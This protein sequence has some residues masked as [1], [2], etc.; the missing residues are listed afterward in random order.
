[1]S[2]A[3]TLKSMKIF[4]IFNRANFYHESVAESGTYTAGA[5]ANIIFKVY[6]SFIASY[7]N[8]E[9]Q[10]KLTNTAG[11]LTSLSKH[12]EKLLSS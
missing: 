2:Q 7:E 5:T 9:V 12:S 4:V 11:K 6:L 3:E 1:M 8:Y 10:V